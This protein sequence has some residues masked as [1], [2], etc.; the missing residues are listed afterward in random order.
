MTG[1]DHPLPT[2][3]MPA[4]QPIARVRRGDVD[5]VLLGTAH[6]SR[7]SAA[8][9]TAMLEAEPFDA[10]AG[11]QLAAGDVAF[12]GLL[13]TAERRPRDRRAQFVAQGAVVGVQLLEGGAVAVDGGRQLGH[14]GGLGWFRRRG[15][16][17][18]GRA[19]AVGLRLRALVRHGG[20][21][22]GTESTKRPGRGAAGVSLLL[23]D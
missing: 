16:R 4:G 14:A 21:E 11:Q 18:R 22:G 20:H 3:G 9:V 12:A 13:R 2:D 15:K 10:V 8:A 17:L 23:E 19:S 5:Y 1:P 7:V 6:V